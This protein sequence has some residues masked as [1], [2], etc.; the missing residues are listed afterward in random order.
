MI[1]DAARRAIEGAG[2]VAAPEGAVADVTVQIGARITATDRS[3][4]DDPFWYGGF[5]AW[6]SPVRLSPLLLRPAVLGAGVALRL[7]RS[8]VRFLLVRPRGR[9]PHPRQAIGRAA[10][11]SAS[12][13]RR[14]DARRR[15]GPAGDVRRR[16]EGFP[17]RQ[18]E[19]PASRHGREGALTRRRRRSRSPCRRSASARRRGSRRASWRPRAAAQGSP[20]RAARWPGRSD[21]PSAAPHSGGRPRA[22]SGR[23]RADR[24]APGRWRRRGPGFDSRRCRASAST[25]RW[26]SLR[27]AK[28]ISALCGEAAIEC[29]ISS[30]CAASRS[31][32]SISARAIWRFSSALWRRCGFL[33]R[34]SSRYSSLVS[35][36][37]LSMFASC[38]GESVTATSAIAGARC[39][40]TG[41]SAAPDLAAPRA[42]ALG[43]RL[44]DDLGLGAR[45]QL[46]VVGK[47]GAP[48]PGERVVERRA[49]PQ[50]L[51]VVELDIAVEPA[52]RE[53]AGLLVAELDHAAARQRDASAPCA[54]AAI[55]DRR[56]TGRRNAG[57]GMGL[58]VVIMAAG[59]GT[60]MKSTRPKVLHT[61]GGRHL[62]Q[63]VLD[64]A[65]ALGE[66]RTIVVTGHGADEVEQKRAGARARRSSASSPS[67]APATR[68][69]RRR[70]CSTP[71]GTTLVLNG[72]VPL[73][74]SET[75]RRLVAAAGPKR[76]VLLT[77]AL[78]EP[79][80]YG[81]IVRAGA[82]A[83]TERSRR[84]SR[85]RTLPTSSARSARS[86]PA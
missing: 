22:A 39:C 14:T 50:R 35:A 32:Y 37:R 18:R 25:S 2:F 27:S 48:M 86:T 57:V 21:A 81:R 26:R 7:L 46:Q 41:S 33:C 74:E 28:A 73:I 34:C 30:R 17:G 13:E 80:G 56:T 8:L 16:D 43:S 77:V 60:R 61:L 53:R 20:Y 11:R 49:H 4:F 52:E 5:G 23:R 40:R 55:I 29:A 59:Q 65:A 54:S 24:R 70:R 38:A 45:E 68:C 6:H 19:Q 10:L 1:E 71:S 47:L 15:D 83:A 3:P 82:A 58:N 85:R 79:R 42:H 51:R 62:L 69:S 84:S 63:H 78:A 67:S 12:R 9:D 76:L 66:T 72:D 75:L 64:A 36:K 31:P 44:A